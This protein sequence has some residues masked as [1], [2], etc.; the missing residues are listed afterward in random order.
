MKWNSSKA[1]ELSCNTAFLKKKMQQ[2]SCLLHHK[3]QSEEGI[4]EIP[5]ITNDGTVMMA[6]GT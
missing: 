2:L 3:T 4:F 1:S 6:I 5:I